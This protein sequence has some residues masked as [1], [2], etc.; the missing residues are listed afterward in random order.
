MSDTADDAQLTRGSA[1]LPTVLLYIF[2][3]V[4]AVMLPLV[5]LAADLPRIGHWSSSSTCWRRF[6][7]LASLGI[8][9]I[10]YLQM[11]K[12]KVKSFWRLLPILLWVVV[13]LH[14][15]S[16]FTQYR[17][18]SWDYGVYEQAARD[19][20]AGKSPYYSD[21]F[22][23]PPLMAQVM[24]GAA[25]ATENVTSGLGLDATR[26]GPWDVV[27]YLYQCMQFLLIILLYWLAY[28]FARSLGLGE[29]AGAVVVS[30]VLLFNTPL[31][32]I[33]RWN[34]IDLWMINTVLAAVLVV[35]HRPY[36]SGLALALGGHIKLYPL[37]IL[38]PWTLA[39]RWRTVVGAVVGGGAIVLLQTDF[40]RSWHL[41][42]EFLS[43]YGQFSLHR[44][45]PINATAHNL[46]YT[47]LYPMRNMF[48]MD[49]STLLA[50]VAW[51]TGVVSMALLIWFAV[52]FFQRERAYQQIAEQDA[53]VSQNASPRRSRLY[54]H[55]MDAIALGLL[56]SPSVWVHHYILALPIAVWLIGTRG[57]NKPWL[58]GVAVALMLLLPATGVFPF[59]YHRAAGIV[60]ALILTAPCHVVRLALFDSGADSEESTA[61]R[62]L[63]R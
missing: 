5:A 31:L 3:A 33:L 56:V 4:V 63:R 62:L 58:V 57:H 17:I 61:A 8:V 40:G 24:A 1:Y 32:D 44:I 13:S 12:L 2:G 21:L 11:E 48:S 28:L 47:L 59:N 6:A 54:G 50:V 38:G 29:A 36:L 14:F 18:K 20:A 26:L 60:M 37:I 30:A 52:R 46:V 43:S 55:A 49:Q 35:Q 27:Y 23:Y 53:T 7:L 41:W 45:D 34:Q 22:R 51:I 10:G 42:Q 25:Q 15:L 19:V 16:L 39:R 9:G